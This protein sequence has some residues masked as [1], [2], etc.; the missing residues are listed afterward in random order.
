MKK[1]EGWK[2]EPARH[3]L[4]SKGIETGRT[5]QKRT[6]HQASSALPS[7]A[8]RSGTLLVK[9]DLKAAAI[10]TIL[11][12]ALREGGDKTH[13]IELLEDDQ[14]LDA[15]AKKVAEAEAIGFMQRAALK[16]EILRTIRKNPPISDE[17]GA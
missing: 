10:D 16:K 3:A 7:Q 1:P 2:K 11:S 4:A 14:W 6:D 17:E 8:L 5:T 13:A 15:E 9:D 12:E